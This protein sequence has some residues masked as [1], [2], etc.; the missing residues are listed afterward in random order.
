[1]PKEESVLL[2]IHGSVA[3]RTQAPKRNMKFV[4][5][6]GALAVVAFVAISMTA[7]KT[8]HRL[9][10]IYLFRQNFVR[11]TVFSG[12]RSKRLLSV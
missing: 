1:M 10:K 9:V 6:A 12:L 4:A 5:F 11:L 2:D 7:Y 3:A 8:D